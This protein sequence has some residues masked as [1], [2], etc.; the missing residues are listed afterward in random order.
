MSRL[1]ITFEM[2]MW[3][4]DR[5]RRLSPHDPAVAAAGALPLYADIG[6]IIAIRPD[7][8]FVEWSHD[9]DGRGAHP[10]ED[11]TWVLLA[12]VAGARR[13]PEFRPL[14]PS[15]GPGA[16]ACDCWEIPGCV[17]GVF[18]CGRC[19]GL[20]WLADGDLRHL[21]ASIERI[22]RPF[23][24][25]GLV[26]VALA[27][28]SF[29]GAVGSFA[30]FWKAPVWYG[31]FLIVLGTFCLVVAPRGIGRRQPGHRQ[32]VQGPDFTVEDPEIAD[33]PPTSTTHLGEQVR[34]ARERRQRA[35]DW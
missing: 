22:R 12:L 33:L 16:V 5:I 7:G 18:S 20:G 19:G 17:S 31:P 1:G 35:G 26:F 2:A 24:R 30:G 3:I 21:P 6:G 23:P 32:V 15:R 28:V 13:Y 25:F 29:W 8:T 14:L 9:S 10:V 34:R 4:A 27:L 11:P